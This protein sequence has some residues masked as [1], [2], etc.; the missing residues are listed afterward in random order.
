M[1]IWVAWIKNLL[2]VSLGF[3][4]FIGAVAVIRW[5]VGSA[6]SAIARIYGPG[7][8][9]IGLAV[10]GIVVGATI[11]TYQERDRSGRQ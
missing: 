11:I 5:V 7:G 8:A 4:L 6:C 3:V 1:S 9:V 10:V 2:L